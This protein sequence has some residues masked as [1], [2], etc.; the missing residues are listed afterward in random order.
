MA[1]CR[2]LD[3]K[4]ASNMLWLVRRKSGLSHFGITFHSLRRGSCTAV[5][6]QRAPLLETKLFGGWK[7]EAVL[8][9]LDDYLA[10]L[11][12]AK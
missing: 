12:M 8:G 4:V 1:V 5:F 9:C 7:S 11:K 6:K 10:K 3:I 2:P